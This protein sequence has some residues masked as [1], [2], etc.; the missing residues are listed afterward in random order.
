MIKKNAT[1]PRTPAIRTPLS[2][3]DVES[4]GLVTGAVVRSENNVL[5]VLL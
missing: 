3:S 5:D 4:S 1:T 2:I